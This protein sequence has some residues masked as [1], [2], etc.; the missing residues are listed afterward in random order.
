MGEACLEGVDS[1]PGKPH[2]LFSE[3]LESVNLEGRQ[4][5]SL[6]YYCARARRLQIYLMGS[7]VAGV[8]LEDVSLKLRCLDSAEIFLLACTR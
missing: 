7:L 4:S 8:Y 5:L 2:G 1:R 3:G 6:S